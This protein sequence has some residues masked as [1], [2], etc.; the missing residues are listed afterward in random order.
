MEE[1]LKL[2]ALKGKGQEFTNFPKT[3]NQKGDMK[4]VL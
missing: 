2:L 1:N 4:E 3:R